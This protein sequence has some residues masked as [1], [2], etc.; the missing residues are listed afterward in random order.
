MPA[1]ASPYRSLP[2][3]LS[4]LRPMGHLGL[5]SFALGLM[6]TF[7]LVVYATWLAFGVVSAVGSAAQ[8]GWFL[9]GSRQND[10]RHGAVAA[11]RTATAPPVAAVP[12]APT[13]SGSTLAFD[14]L[15]TCGD[16]DTI[17]AGAPTV[18]T[19]AHTGESVIQVPVTL[20]N[21]T[22]R[23]WSPVSTTFAGTLDRAP[24]VESAEGDWMYA[25]PI[26]PHTSVTLT[27]VF[28][29]GAGRFA[30]TV[31]TPHGVA[32]FTGRV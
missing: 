26:V 30:L 18:G 32:S 13:S 8:H 24:V 16:G 28:V 2:P 6:V 1:P 5:V 14:Q 23:D 11:E 25:A 22:E 9:H 12:V 4:P 15:W 19:S 20:T 10:R 27:K 3:H 17:V 21:N 7:G 29:G 31:S